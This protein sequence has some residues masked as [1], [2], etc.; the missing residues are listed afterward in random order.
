MAL[1][2]LASRQKDK[3]KTLLHSAMLTHVTV[4]LLLVLAMQQ[5]RILQ[6]ARNG[7]DRT[8]IGTLNCRT[9]LSDSRMFELDTAL[10]A[11]GMD[12][13]ALQETRRNGFLSFNTENY[14]VYYFGECSG[15]NGVGIAVHKR[16]THLI[17]SPRGIPSS[18]GRLMTIDILLHDVNHPVNHPFI[19][20]YAPTSKATVQVRN[21]FYTQLAK[22]TSPN[23]WLIGDFNARVG[24]RPSD[25]LSG[26]DACNTIGPWS[27]K[28]DV[29][30]NS[31]GT[32]LLNLVS[33]HNLRHV[34]SHFRFRDSKRWTWRHP[35]Y[36]SRAVLDHVFIPASHMRFVSRCFVPSDIAIS[37]DHR[38]VICELNFRPRTTPK[39]TA[40]SPKLNIRALTDSATERL[41]QSE[42]ER[43]LGDRNPENLQ[44]EVVASSIRSATVSSA[45]ITLPVAQKS[46][47]P[48]EFQPA[49][50]SLIHR[51]RRLWQRMQK[52][53]RRVTRSLRSVFRSLCQEIK[54]DIKQDQTARREKD[55]FS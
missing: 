12:I 53:G 51:K 8:R 17:S 6:R 49:T 46:K 11:K 45:K 18:D 39:P 32:L 31:N 3:P 42:V 34:S 26:I 21:K 33:E 1:S 44:S 23:T 20:S 4:L 27:L 47:F 35:H 38:P 50:V 37:T 15:K 10:T 5:P 7:H 19:C 36:R 14:V 40:S 25:P 24:R 41:F 43:S 28:N 9:L 48:S 22:L 2:L 16:F 13:C 52:S 55:F 30:P 29:T 54:I